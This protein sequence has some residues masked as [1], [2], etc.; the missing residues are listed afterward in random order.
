MRLN[1]ALR[2]ALLLAVLI[3]GSGGL[4]VAGDPTSAAMPS[5]LLQSPGDTLGL[6]Q[7]SPARLWTTAPR[8]GTQLPHSESCTAPA[9]RQAGTTETTIASVSFDVTRALAGSEYADSS[10]PQH[11]P[12]F[13]LDVA[14]LAVCRT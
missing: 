1:H 3:C 5:A 7:S 2:L 8:G 12:R 10:Y 9:T 13:G 14:G 4:H 6:A 11:V